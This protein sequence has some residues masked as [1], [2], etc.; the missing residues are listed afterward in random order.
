MSRTITGAKA[1]F[2]INA[3]PI[4][5]ASSCSYEWAHTVTPVQ[6]IDQITVDE[7]AETGMTIAFSC[8]T[9][10]VFKRSAISLGLQPKLRTL[11]QQPEMVVALY[12]RTTNDLLLRIEGVKLTSR[13]G[14]LDARGVWTETLSFVGRTASDEEGPI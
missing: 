11:L 1:L 8:S 4:V 9:F 13:S 3:T 14:N 2:T 6:G 5:Y 7:Q 10:R 12:D